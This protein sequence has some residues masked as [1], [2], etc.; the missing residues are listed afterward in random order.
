MAA[1]DYK[2]QGGVVHF[3]LYSTLW[4]EGGLGRGGVLSDR[5]G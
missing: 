1:S 2:H 5:D 3:R 4:S